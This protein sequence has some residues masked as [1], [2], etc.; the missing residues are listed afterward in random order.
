LAVESGGGPVAPDF[1]TIRR[2]EWARG[3]KPSPGSWNWRSALAEQEEG[4]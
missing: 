4:D 2:G 3:V 1:G